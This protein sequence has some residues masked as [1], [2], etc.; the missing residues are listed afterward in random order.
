MKTR[1]GSF[2]KRF[3]IIWRLFHFCVILT[4]AVSII[5]LISGCAG[6]VPENDK[7][8][9]TSNN[10]RVLSLPTYRN[11]MQR[12]LDGATDTGAG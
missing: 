11:T 4:L 6:P 1:E 7:P 10:R 8:I 5:A 12:Y 9:A 2:T 3:N